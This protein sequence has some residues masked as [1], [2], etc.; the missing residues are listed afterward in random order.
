ME[1]KTIRIYTGDD[2]EDNIDIILLDSFKINKFS[3]FFIQPEDEEFG[4]YEKQKVEDKFDDYDIITIYSRPRGG[5][6]ATHYICINNVAIMLPFEDDEDPMAYPNMILPKFFENKKYNEFIE[7]INVKIVDHEDVAGIIKLQ[8]EFE[9]E[10]EEHQKMEKE[11]CGE[12]TT[13]ISRHLEHISYWINENKL[14]KPE[15]T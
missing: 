13:S 10:F 14:Y 4:L 3:W 8:T 12:I 7:K 1:D 15:K 6:F 9:E 2:P 5:H 11:V